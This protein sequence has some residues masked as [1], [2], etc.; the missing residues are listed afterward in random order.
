VGKD[1]SIV[2]IARVLMFF[3]VQE[4]R[5]WLRTGTHTA[6]RDVDPQFVRFAEGPHGQIQQ[7]LR[8]WLAEPPQMKPYLRAYLGAV[9]CWAG[10]SA[11]RQFRRLFRFASRAAAGTG[12][13]ACDWR[14][15][16]IRTLRAYMHESAGGST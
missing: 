6:L 11:F 4:R 8:I 1:D 14:R 15:L 16:L 10:T 3:Y 13:P 2:R 7:I 9:N 12:Q 5:M